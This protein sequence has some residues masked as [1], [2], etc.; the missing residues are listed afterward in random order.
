ME[1]Y[2][3]YFTD[4]NVTRAKYK[5]IYFIDN[6]FEFLTTSKNII[7]KSVQ[8]HINDSNFKLEPIMK[9]FENSESLKNYIQ[10]K[11]IKHIPGITC[12]FTNYYDEH[13]AHGLYDTLY[14]IYHCFL[15]AGYEN[16]RFNIL[17]QLGNFNLINKNKEIYKKFSK[18]DIF[19]Y[20]ESLLKDTSNYR[21][22]VVVSGSQSAGLTCCNKN[23]TLIGGDINAMQKFR[24]R[25][26]SVYEIN[27]NVINKNINI[28]IIDNKR[29]SETT[30]KI[31]KDICIYLNNTGK[32][33][34]NYINYGT[35][36]IFK[37]QLEMINNIDIHI[38]GPGSGMLNFPF[39]RDNSRHI[40]LG[41]TKY[42]WL[43]RE[44]EDMTG[45]MEYTITSQVSNYINCEFYDI[46]KNKS[47]IFNKLLELIINKDIEK[48]V[49]PD[50]IKVW[51]EYCEID[52]INM[53]N[54]I[55]RMNGR[56]PELTGYRFPE[57]MIQEKG[58]FKENIENPSMNLICHKLLREIKNK[59][60]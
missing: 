53:E 35:L 22:D 7:I 39:L 46:K 16:E 31:L 36:P 52:N 38:S 54:L 43:G 15:R 41:A 45:Y 21:F 17:Y 13:H 3:D 5:N 37:N 18:G 40:N 26:L 27:S 56:H 51:K 44:N 11:T 60:N 25:M 32:F 30:K 34:C 23:A 47:V 6:R 10:K 14:P 29:Y 55:A 58:I 28:A 12:F 50:Y 59:Y 24:N 19:I 33:K 57:I 20:F 49:I 1:S 2:V 9:V 42:T 8:T 4:N 48:I